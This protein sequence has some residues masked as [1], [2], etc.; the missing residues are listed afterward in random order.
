MMNNNKILTVSY[1]TFSCTLEGFDDSFGT[2]KAIAEYFRDLAADDRYFG[3]EPPQPDAEMLARIAQKEIS[4]KV[5]A[6][7]HEGKIVLSA[8]EHQ[9][10]EVAEVVTEAPAAPA[11]V[12]ESEAEPGLAAVAE[13]EAEAP[14]AAEE[15]EIEEEVAA[16]TEEPAAAPEPDVGAADID[17]SSLVRPDAAGTVTPTLATQSLEV[18]EEPEEAVAEE[19]ADFTPQVS[20]EAVEPVAADTG[21][22]DEAVI[23]PDQPDEEVEAFFAGSAEHDKQ[24]TDEYEDETIEVEAEPVEDVATAPAV[25]QSI[26]EKLQRIR[27]VVAKTQQDDADDEDADFLEDEHANFDEP[28]AAT[29]VMREAVEDIEEAMEADDA[30]E[31][32]RQTVEEATTDEAAEDEDDDIDAILA[33][34]DQETEA[35]SEAAEAEEETLEEIAEEPDLSALLD[36]VDAE[37][38]DAAEDRAMADAVARAADVDT[39]DAPQIVSEAALATSDA[40]QPRARVFKVKRAELD[41]AIARGDLE[42]YDDDEDLD[43]VAEAD[44]P[45]LD[46]IAPSKTNETSLSRE[47]EEDLARELAALQ[48]DIEADIEADIDEDDTEEVA[49]AEAAEEAEDD[50]FDE[51][52]TDQDA[53]E[54]EAQEVDE[55]D[56]D[57]DLEDDH[58]ELA[59][60]A[61]RHRLPDLDED[62]DNDMDRLLAEADHKMDEPESA[63]RRN[64]FTH[65]R[66]A[67]AA[68]KADVAM[69]KPE[70][71]DLNDDAYRSDLAQVVRPRRP[72]GT[73]PRTRRPDEGRPAP[74]KL[75]AEQRIDVDRPS[76]AGPVR[77]RRVAAVAEQEAPVQ[78]DDSFADYAQDMGATT[79]PQL[80]EAAASY[81]SFVEGRDQFSRPQLMTKVRQAGQETEFSREDGLRSFGQLLRAGKISKI[82]GGRFTVSEDIGFRPDQRA[83]G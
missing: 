28:P 41:A 12:A 2:M 77:P 82:K 64:A 61:T 40:L 69:G 38:E 9:R 4:R 7:E 48:A 24:I 55:F 27:A 6:R 80:L 79:L 46:G 63:G 65:L 70:K 47:E 16:E 45:D 31:S 50:D 75:V 62:A 11:P 60:E 68:K 42:E 51:E 20:A 49:E 43:E 57:E 21:E 15:P 71:D 1:G 10:E 83:A 8:L 37:E 73:A 19:A 53:A 35:V 14:E 26:A 59:A 3:A 30:A 22:E 78:G 18:R 13:A 72:E 5:E 44:A 39:D 33:R 54:A 76:P 67:V 29:D 32:L 52:E 25:G 17:L 23:V 56:L 74:L 58:E 34:L 81:M 36:A 66:A